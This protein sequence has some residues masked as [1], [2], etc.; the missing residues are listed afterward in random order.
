MLERDIY[1][2]L[3]GWHILELTIRIIPYIHHPWRCSKNVYMWH[4]GIW[5]SRHGG[6]GVMVGLDDL[7]G[8]FQ[9]MILYMLAYKF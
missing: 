5:F 6:V 3:L 9:P 4:F 1:L 8:L 7:R 2:D